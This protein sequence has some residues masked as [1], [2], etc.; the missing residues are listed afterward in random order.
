MLYH[1]L[2]FVYVKFSSKKILNVLHFPSCLG[3]KIAAKGILLE[4]SYGIFLEVF[5]M[6]MGNSVVSGDNEK[7]KMTRV[8]LP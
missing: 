3:V 7:E 6:R 1:K 2:I 4:G 5:G 8:G